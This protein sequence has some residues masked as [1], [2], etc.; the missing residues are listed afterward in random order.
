NVDMDDG[1]AG[2]VFAGVVGGAVIEART[3]RHDQ[4]GVVHGHVG[5]VG[6]VHAEHADELLVVVGEAAQAHQGVGHREAEAVRHGR[7][8]F[9]GVAADDAA[10]G[11]DHRALG[12]HQFLYRLADLAGMATR[13]RRVGAHLDLF[14]ELVRQ[15]HLRGGL[16]FRDIDQHRAG[17]A[18][19]GDIER[20]AHDLGNVLGAADH[21]AV[22]HDRAA[23][24][25]HV[26]FLEGVIADPVRADLSGDDDHRDGI[27]VGG[28]NAGHGI[29]GAWAGSDQ[30]HARLAG[31]A[32]IAV[33]GMGGGLFV[34][35]QDVLDFVL[36]EDGVVNVQHRA[37]RIA[38]KVF[39]PLVLQGADEHFRTG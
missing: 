4:V 37:A 35:H 14:R 2:A 21:E 11:V 6:A 8:Q 18:G 34:A 29:G 33:G 23:D 24:A 32:G 17:A 28:G 7:Q 16:V 3:Y 31:G 22:L 38:K 36:L 15:L 5:F 25:D 9:A 19:G 20:L 26:G 39:N 30:H 12:L 10:A 1:R 27:H 13:H